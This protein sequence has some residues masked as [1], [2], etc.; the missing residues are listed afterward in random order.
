MIYPL[1]NFSTKFEHNCCRKS[2]TEQTSLSLSD[3]LELLGVAGIDQIPHGNDSAPE[4]VQIELGIA[5]IWFDDENSYPNSAYKNNPTSIPF[6]SGNIPSCSSLTAS[7]HSPTMYEFQYLKR[8]SYSRFSTTDKVH[9]GYID[10]FVMFS[11]QHIRLC[12]DYDKALRECQT[13]IDWM[14]AG[15]LYFAE[16]FNQEDLD[17]K[18]ALFDPQFHGDTPHPILHLD[19]KSPSMSLFGIEAYECFAPGKCIRPGYVEVKETELE[20]LRE[21]ALLYSEITTRGRRK[22]EDRKFEKKV[23]NAAANRKNNSSL[24]FSGG[25]KNGSSSRR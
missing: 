5:S 7:P 11:S 2:Q 10:D 20:R 17:E 12:L 18:L 23:A 25:K 8:K 14:P 22:A 15:Y 16:A 24:H 4:N 19:K 9:D 3:Y 1:F 13:E 6:C 21:T